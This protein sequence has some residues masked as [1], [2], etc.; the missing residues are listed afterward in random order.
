MDMTS[1]VK[2]SVAG[3][4]LVFAVIGFVYWF[5][6]FKKADGAPRFS[7]NVLL[8]VSMSWGLIIGGGYMVTQTR[9][10]AVDGWIIFTYWFAVFIYGVA[11]GLVAS[12]IYSAVKDVVEKQFSKIFDLVK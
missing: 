5:K 4:P 2:A 11:M 9:P 7:G 10:P 6:Q 3:V 1:F 12:G 8:L